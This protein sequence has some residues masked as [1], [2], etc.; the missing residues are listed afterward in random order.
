[1]FIADSNNWCVRKVSPDGIITTWA[2]GGD[3]GGSSSDGNRATNA[4]LFWQSGGLAVDVA[5]NLFIATYGDGTVHKVDP[6]GTITTVARGSG[7][8]T[9]VAVGLDGTLYFSQ[10][11][12]FRDGDERILKLSPDGQVTTIAGRGPSGYT[13]DGGPAADAQ[14]RLPA[15]LAADKSGNV[16]FADI[17][18]GVVR[19][20]RPAY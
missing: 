9:G 18:N 11:S 17:G 13:G 7:D 14:L 2:G 5:G 8:V 4:K 10:T 15:G 20:L 1:L 16:Y 19:V 12:D 6:N 3:L